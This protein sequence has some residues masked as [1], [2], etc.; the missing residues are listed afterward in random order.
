MSDSDDTPREQLITTLQDINDSIKRI[1]AS[2]RRMESSLKHLYLTYGQISSSA[3]QIIKIVANP[4]L[5]AESLT[6]KSMKWNKGSMKN[7][8]DSRIS[9]WTRNGSLPQDP[10]THENTED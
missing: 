7:N 6:R 8:I 4:K 5:L 3:D 1:I 10:S 2:Q 9:L